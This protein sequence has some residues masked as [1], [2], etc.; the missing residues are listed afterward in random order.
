VKNRLLKAK[1]EGGEVDFVV[2]IYY[3]CSQKWVQNGTIGNNKV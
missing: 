1:R 2:K 3:N